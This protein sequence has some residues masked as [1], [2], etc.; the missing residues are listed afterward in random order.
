M[1]DFARRDAS[2]PSPDDVLDAL[3]DAVFEPV[4]ESV[5]L[6]AVR[7]ATARSVAEQL[8]QRASTPDLNP[9][10]RTRL[11]RALDHAARHLDETS[12]SHPRQGLAADIRRFLDRDHAP[13]APTW[14]AP[15]PPPGS[16]IGA[17]APWGCGF[18]DLTPPN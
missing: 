7:Q 4:A 8:I 16:P 9:E 17:E 2:M 5:R 12:D 10:V 1:I 3:V 13:A 15:A 6:A 18:M 11:E 14:A